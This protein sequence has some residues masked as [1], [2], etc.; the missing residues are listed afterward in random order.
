[1]ETTVFAIESVARCTGLARFPF[2]ESSTRG[3]WP[4]VNR[5]LPV[6][7][8]VPVETLPRSFEMGMPL[9]AAA[10]RRVLSD[11]AICPTMVG[12]VLMLGTETLP[13]GEKGWPR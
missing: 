1:M 10:F 13:V 7:A 11:R 3:F 8:T 5:V 9:S 12:L 4:G 6:V 2:T